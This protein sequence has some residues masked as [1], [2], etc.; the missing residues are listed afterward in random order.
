MRQ[1]RF[2]RARASRV[3]YVCGSDEYGTAT[4]TKALEEGVDPPTLCA[5][6]HAIHKEI[7][8]W[9]R[10]RFDVFGRTPTLQQT[11]IVQAIF[12]DLWKNGLIEEQESTQPFC[13]VE[14]HSTVSCARPPHAGDGQLI[15]AWF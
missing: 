3:L 11:Q 9:F 13:P 4:E 8:D 15:S 2:C 6:Y 10:I 1:A 12:T 14:G 5:K 7:Y